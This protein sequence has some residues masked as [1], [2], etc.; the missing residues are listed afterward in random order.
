MS[1]PIQ[2]RE[3]RH[4]SRYRS[5]F[6]P[7]VLIGIGVIWLLVNLHVLTTASLGVLVRFW[8]V[9]LI[10][11]G[12]NIIF[13]RRYAIIGA[14]LG[15]ITVGLII[16]ASFFASQWNL[17]NGASFFGIPVHFYDSSQVKT[18]QYSEPVGQAK[19]TAIHMDLTRGHTVVKSLADSSDLVEA[20]V[21][22][23]GDFT[24]AVEGE[25]NKTVTLGQTGLNVVTWFSPVQS[26]DLRWDIGLSPQIPINL[27]VRAGSGPNEFDLSHLQL[28]NVDFEG[29]SGATTLQFPVTEVRL[30][31]KIST[32]SGSFAIT[33]PAHSTSDLDLETASGS[34][35]FTLGEGSDV[36]LT[37][38]GASGS[39]RLVIGA[40]TLLNAKIE[41]A[42]G[43]VNID[44]PTDTAV[45]LEVTDAGSGSISVPS[46]MKRIQGQGKT[47]IWESAGYAS[48][49][50]RITISLHT[51][52]GS[53]YIN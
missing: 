1:E 24:F 9:L 11:I 28:S 7:V 48:A 27:T 26:D 18:A 20:S 19:T 36:N 16:F 49:K 8:P 12:L 53:F 15:L 13:A 14:M 21:K 31:A 22:Y 33:M 23:I 38:S 43:S 42:S 34:V 4:R 29:A 35:S 37:L 6:W 17:S 40:N 44:I 39:Q 41:S 47:G 30:P 5:F 32:A 3:Y 51:G 10:L 50:N 2:Q 25:E 45:R 46:W 52:S